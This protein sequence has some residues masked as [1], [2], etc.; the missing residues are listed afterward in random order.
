MQLDAVPTPALV[1]DRN[2]L[3]R[4]VAAMSTRMNDHGVALRPHLKTSKSAEVARL[5]TSGHSGAITVS[6]LAE[7]AYFLDKGFTD[8]TYAVGFV[9]SKAP[10]A[11]ALMAR[12][13]RLTLVTDNLTVTQAMAEIEVDTVFTMLVEIDCGDKRAGVLADGPE[14]LDIART[15]HDSKNMTLAGVMTHA[16]HSYGAPDIAGVKAI[17]EDERLAVVRAAER[18]REA[19]LPCPVVSAGSTPTAMLAECFNGL[20]E[21]R[22]GVY[23]FLDLTQLSH[24]ICQRGDLALSV[25]A[26]VIGHNR[27]AG[28]ILLDAGALAL[29]KDIGANAV[30]PETGYGD[31]CDLTMRPLEGLHVA[32][33]S[34]E[35]G[36]VPVSNEAVYDQ[37]PVGSKVRV[38]PNHA[39]I[40][41]AAYPSYNVVEGARVVDEW[42]RVNGW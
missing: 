19:G 10:Q 4:N 16:G 9:P 26:S 14:L 31:V 35:H 34:Q 1:L 24:G 11:I 30:W 8:I 3:M 5:A 12:G 7:A 28:H 33:V 23:M 37:L 25:L 40:T 17:A 20:T 22:P 21:M 29:S 39:C 36:I 2:I 38:A 41:A 13:A 32:Q 6:T 15:I 27:H 18:L 42:D